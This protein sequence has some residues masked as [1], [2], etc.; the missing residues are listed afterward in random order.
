MLSTWI[1]LADIF[2]ILANVQM[3]NFMVKS[4]SWLICRSCSF[5]DHWL[6]VLIPQYTPQAFFGCICPSKDLRQW[7]CNQFAIAKFQIVCFR[8]RICCCYKKQNCSWS[9]SNAL[10]VEE[11]IPISFI[12]SRSDTSDG[13]YKLRH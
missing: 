10:M 8:D 5:L 12:K 9:G 11:S 3:A 4:S 6:S 13:L 1:G 2:H 7:F